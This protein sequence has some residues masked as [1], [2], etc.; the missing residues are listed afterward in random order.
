MSSGEFVKESGLKILKGVK[1]ALKTITLDIDEL[2][3]AKNKNR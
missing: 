3:N 2:E 1:I